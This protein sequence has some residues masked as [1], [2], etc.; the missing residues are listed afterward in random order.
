VTGLF[1]LLLLLLLLVLLV[2]IIIINNNK[3]AHCHVARGPRCCA[4]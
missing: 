2:L 3:S 1:E 4:W